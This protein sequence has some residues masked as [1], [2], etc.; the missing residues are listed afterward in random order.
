MKMEKLPVPPAI[1]AKNPKALYDMPVVIIRFL[2]TADRIHLDPMKCPG[3][4]E[5]GLTALEEIQRQID[6]A[7]PRICLLYTS[8]AA[9]E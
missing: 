6:V 1:S 3:F 8:D 7:N 9:D 4:Y 5:P 2:P